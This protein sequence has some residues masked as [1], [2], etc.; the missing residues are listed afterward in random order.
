MTH[1]LDV[2]E[3]LGASAVGEGLMTA[4][5]AI[6]STSGAD[7]RG[8]GTEPPVVFAE[9]LAFGCFVGSGAREG[10]P[11][12]PDAGARDPAMPAEEPAAGL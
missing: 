12:A 2:M 1:S 3:I 7:R 8:R 9:V 6:L 4:A 11:G 10:G 5:M